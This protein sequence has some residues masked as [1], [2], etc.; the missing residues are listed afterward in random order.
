MATFGRAFG[1][2]LA[3]QGTLLNY[4][5]LEFTVEENQSAVGIIIEEDA[6]SFTIIIG[7]DDFDIDSSG[8]ITFKSAPNYQVINKYILYVTSNKYKR[9]K[10]TVIVTDVVS[11]FILNTATVLNLTTTI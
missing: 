10:V 11:T 7:Y 6:T 5:P 3:Q 8:V 9:Y 2:S 4:I 1:N